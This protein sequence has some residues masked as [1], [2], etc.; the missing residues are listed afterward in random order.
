MKLARILLAGALVPAACGPVEDDKSDRFNG[1]SSEAP[2]AGAETKDGDEQSADATRKGNDDEDDL[3]SG[4]VSN[5]SEPGDVPSAED[6][7]D[8]PGA[9]GDL[10]GDETAE[11]GDEIAEEPAPAPTENDIFRG[12]P[13]GMDQMKVICARPGRDKVRQVF[14]GPNP[15]TVT[16]LVELQTAL[17]LGFAAPQTTGRGNNG[18]NGNPGFAITGHSSSLVARF[19]S[20]INPRIILFTPNNT[21]DFVSLGFVR[22]EQFAEII[23]NDPDTD[24]AAFFLVK[25]EQA[26]GEECKPGDLLTP[27]VEKNWTKFTLYEDTDIKNT[28]ADCMQC[29]QPA[30]PGTPKM[31]RMQELRNPWTHFFR[32]NTGGGQALIA[33][34]QAAHGTTEDYGGIPAAQITSSEP[35]ILETFVRNNGFGNQPNEFPTATIERQVR[36]SSAA[37]PADNSTPGVSAAWTNIYNQARAGN[38]IAVPYHDV[39]VTDPTKL[40]AMTAA[41]KAVQA[42]TMPQA[43][44]PDIR[45]VFLDSRAHEMGFGVQPGSTAQEILMQAC[46]QCHNS[47]LDQTITR[48]RFNVDLSTMDRAE[49][50]L[51]IQRLKLT[52]HDPKRMPPE[53]FRTLTDAE[54]QSLIEL[55]QQ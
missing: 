53:R 27:A 28:V 4:A 1:S 37:Q 43:E 20:A 18:R 17:G 47:R 13:D 26:C 34:F 25:F 45:D 22:G 54:I 12:L 38:V 23:A 16:S 15:P 14:C 9:S 3:D 24:V 35:A 2:L 36:A 30:G 40:A 52:K 50:D 10:P 7:L 41:Y 5:A 42:G 6:D 21:N 11:P 51:A 49:K 31:L 8:A 39:K 55:L 29:H 33:D 44:L 46:A 48:A 32:N 19:V